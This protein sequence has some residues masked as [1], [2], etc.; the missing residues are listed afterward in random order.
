MTG[1]P[2]SLG[3]DRRRP[4]LA[5]SLRFFARFKENVVIAIG[6][7]LLIALLVAAWRRSAWGVAVLGIAVGASASGPISGAINSIVAAGTSLANSLNN[8]V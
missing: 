5:P 1:G 2:G 4:R 6:A 8:L 3:P 7:V